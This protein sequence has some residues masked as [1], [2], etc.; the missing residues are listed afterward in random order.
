[1]TEFEQEYVD[2]GTDRIAVHHFPAPER[3]DAPVVVIWPAMGTPARFYRHLVAG[4]REHGLAVIAVD[5]RG[6][7]AS[8]PPPSRRSRY[9]YAEL[10]ADVGAVLD[11]LKSRVDGRPVYLLGHS[12]GGQA[13]LLHLASTGDT[14]VAGVILV[15]VGLPWYRSYG[16]RAVPTLAMTQSV[17]ATAALLRV[18]PGWGFGGRQ[19]HGVIR[20]WGYTARHGRFPRLDGVDVDAALASIR[21][22]I[23]AISVAADQY[24]PPATT[25]HLCS[26]MP[27]AP[28]ERVHLTAAEAGAPLDHFTWARQPDAVVAR[29]VEFVRKA[30]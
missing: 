12:L 18:W 16:G 23:L 2:R 10:T 15:A 22:P 3:P 26:K 30:R 21:T 7:G 17:V 29:V 20:D 5:L 8:T 27:A 9:G 19:A 14:S 24:T 25:D 11:A 6:T 13:C 4:L 1:M 28:I